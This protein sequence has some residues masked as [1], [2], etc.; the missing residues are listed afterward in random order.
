[1]IYLIKSSRE[2]KKYRNKFILFRYEQAT[3][4]NE[5]L[6][7]DF[8]KKT[9]RLLYMFLKNIIIQILFLYLCNVHNLDKLYV[10]ILVHDIV[11]TL[12]IL[13]LSFLS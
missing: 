10:V 6:F 2:I 3:E 1:M 13:L 7:L 9:C 8:N 4:K 12:R 11:D 5:N